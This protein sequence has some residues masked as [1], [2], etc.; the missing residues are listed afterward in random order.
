MKYLPR[1]I[2]TRLNSYATIVIMH[3]LQI[4]ATNLNN[5]QQVLELYQVAITARNLSPE[6]STKIA[7][8]AFDATHPSNLNFQPSNDLEKLRF[9]MGALEAPGDF[10]SYPNHIFSS[11]LEFENFLWN[12]L[13]R[14]VNEA[15]QTISSA[16]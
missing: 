13:A 7:I 6:D 15:S 4:K 9:E 16:E 8:L 10:L 1:K 14:L 11:Q 5:Q 2:I 12:R 3:K